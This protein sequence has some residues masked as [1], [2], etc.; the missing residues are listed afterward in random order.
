MSDT[1]TNVA[2]GLI[3]T[4][5]VGAALDYSLDYANGMDTGA[6]LSSSTWTA[7]PNDLTLSNAS[8]TNTAVSVT[9]TGGT[10]GQWYVVS[11]LAGDTAG[12]IHSGQFSLQVIDPT[13]LNL[14]LNLPFPSIP[15]ALASL[16]RDRLYQLMLTFAPGGTLEDSYLLEK[17]NAATSLIQ[18]RLRVFLTPRE[19]VPNTATQDEI[20]ALTGAGNI[21]ATEPS[22]DYDPALFQGNT[23]GFT[24]LRQRPIIAVHSMQFVYPT[25]NQSIFTIPTSWIRFD[26][27]AGTI[28]LLPV[29][30]PL[31]LPLNAFILAALG[32][33]RSV[34]QF[35]EI[36][37]RAGLA[38]CA[39]DWPEILDVILKQTALSIVEDFY[40]P[41]SKSESVS[42]DGLTQ[43]SAIGLK[44]GEYEEQIGRKVEAIRSALFGVRLTVI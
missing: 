26:A 19:I 15:G 10:A 8:F 23:W 17:L 44:T 16:R 22:Y 29:Q 27:R 42:A 39:R 14:Q 41:S 34:P 25:P 32:G 40:I 33:G 37:Y 31:T 13:A 20:D 43:S 5:A 11:N 36:R 28:N 18:H 12:D 9:C 35:L 3:A 30:Q 4:K 7:T 2:G 1:L 38:N 24:L 6:I 21:V